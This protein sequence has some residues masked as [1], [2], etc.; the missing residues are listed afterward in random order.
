MQKYFDVSRNTLTQAFNL[1]NSKGYVQ[2]GVKTPYTVSFTSK[3][4]ILESAGWEYYINNGSDFVSAS[5]EIVRQNRPAKQYYPQI[6]A[7]FGFPALFKRTLRKVASKL[8]TVPVYHNIGGIPPLLK[9]ISQYLNTLKIE[10]DESQILITPSQ[11]TSTYVISMGLF[12]TATTVLA[13]EPS[14]YISYA[15]TELPSKAAI[16]SLKTDKYGPVLS[17]FIA[18][19]ENFPKLVLYM[20]PLCAWPEGTRILT[21]RL[22]EISVYC[23]RHRIPIIEL[24]G[25][26]EKYFRGNPGTPLK[27]ED[28][29]GNIIYNSNFLSF[30]SPMDHIDFIVGPSYVIEHL[31][32]VYYQIKQHS[33]YIIQLMMA[34]MLQSGDYSDFILSVRDKIKQRCE[35]ARALLL[36]YINGYAYWSNPEG[37]ISLVITFIPP[38]QAAKLSLDTKTCSWYPLKHFGKQYNN[39]IILIFTSCSEDLLERFIASIAVEI[40]KQV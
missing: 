4:P 15:L 25:L 33:P 14:Y 3:P 16:F 7:E 21:E 11:Q 2:G 37:G 35:Y 13:P 36:K 10:A 40:D 29:I 39:S 12:N 20:E 30:F 31:T 27:A 18:K 28:K 8:K 6:S 19:T 38:V 9:S 5:V 24:D 26:R 32:N 17:D 22:S 1:L 34:E 23:K